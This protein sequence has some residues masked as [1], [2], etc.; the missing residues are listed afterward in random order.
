MLGKNR[1]RELQLLH[2]KKHR[3]EQDLFLAEGAKIVPELLQSDFPVKEV[4]ALDSW[5][6]KNR[7]LLH[8]SGCVFTSITQQDLER[9]SQ[10]QTPQEVIAL[11][12]K[13]H[14]NAPEMESGKLYLLMDSI[15]DPGNMGTLLRL[16]DWFGIETVYATNDSVEWTNPKVIQATMG[17]FIRIR[18][19]Y[20]DAAK[21]LQ[22]T[23]NAIPIYAADLEGENLYSGDFPAEGILIISNEAHGL[24]PELEN[25][26]TRKL[27]IPAFPRNGKQPESLNAAMAGA[28]VLGEFSRR[29]MLGIKTENG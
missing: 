21:M 20:V 23:K 12:G 26:L 29:R 16:A 1:L 19:V 25:L 24:S 9:L 13:P 7:A 6:D 18:P 4:F 22:E 3:E 17:S 14:E 2:Q 11:C 8:H 5:I 27:H 28:I 10:L 15:R